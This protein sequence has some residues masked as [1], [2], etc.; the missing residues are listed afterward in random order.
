MMLFVVVVPPLGL[1]VMVD[2]VLLVLDWPLGLPPVVGLYIWGA[3]IVPYGSFGLPPCV[4]A[5]LAEIE[6]SIVYSFIF[7]YFFEFKHWKRPWIEESFE[8]VDMQIEPLALNC[9]PFW[10]LHGLS[11]DEVSKAEF[12]MFDR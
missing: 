3:T 12:A 1:V 4:A 10:L 2:V 11:I 7:T 8:A 5:R 6:G 9:L